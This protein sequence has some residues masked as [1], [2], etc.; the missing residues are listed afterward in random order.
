MLTFL[1]DVLKLAAFH[2]R[3]AR[4]SSLSFVVLLVLAFP[5][6]THLQMS[7][8][9]ERVAVAPRLSYVPYKPAS[10]LL[11]LPPPLQLTL[12][13]A[14]KPTSPRSFTTIESLLL[15]LT[16]ARPIFGH[17]HADF[18]H[19]LADITTPVHDHLL[20]AQNYLPIDLAVNSTLIKLSINLANISQKYI[21]RSPT[22]AST[23]SPCCPP[24]D[25]A[26]P[27]CL[28]EINALMPLNSLEANKLPLCPTEA[29]TLTPCCPLEVDTLPPL[30]PLEINSLPLHPL[31]INSLP[32]LLSSTGWWRTLSPT[33]LSYGLAALSPTQ[34]FYG[35]LIKELTAAH[36][37]QPFELS[38]ALSPQL[39]KELTAAHTPKPF[40]LSAALLL[41]TNSA[42]A[43]NVLSP[44]TLKNDM[45]TKQSA[46]A[47]NVLS[48]L[49][50]KT[51]MLA[52]QSALALNVLSPLTLKT[53]MLAEQSALALN[54]L[55]PLTLKTDM[56][57]EQSALA[58]NVLSPLT[59]KTDTLAEQSALAL[60]V[61]SPLTL[62]TDMLAE[63]SAL[64]LNVLSSL[65]LAAD[66]LSLSALQTIPLPP[67]EPPPCPIEAV[68]QAISPQSSSL[69]VHSSL[70][71]Y[72]QA[73]PSASA[74]SD[75]LAASS[76]L[77]YMHATPSVLAR[78]DALAASSPLHYMHATPS[79]SARSDALA[80]SSPPHYIHATPSASA[81]SDV[82]VPSSL[83]HFRKATPSALARS[84]ALAASSPPHYI[85]ATPSASARSDA[86]EASPLSART[87]SPARSAVTDTLSQ[88]H[89]LPSPARS[90]SCT[91]FAITGLLCHHQHA[92]A[93]AR[94][95]VAAPE[96][97]ALSPLL[98]TP[99]IQPQILSK[100]Q[101]HIRSKMQL[102][103]LSKDQSSRSW[104]HR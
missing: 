2:L 89:A 11:S 66:M 51:D 4:G 36:T 5:S 75:A 67:G 43:L 10:K 91:H 102:H 38:A 58:L 93:A 39:I 28:T 60:N 19:A 85:R 32:L 100:V 44:L 13:A 74:R 54:V 33:Q 82:L 15:P 64:A 6:S 90:R 88:L 83:L 92:L 20:D 35:L 52:E 3:P 7:T 55:S 76:P 41:A 101:L 14:P 17:A 50:L 12:A 31:E 96:P 1:A 70:L 46:L 63:Q 9:I 23:L 80:A 27:P 99:A 86:L 42:P 79:A 95:D 104:R 47:L 16:T 68:L 78:S 103:I 24:E 18:G 8:R 87:P 26:H 48:P 34:L 40:E 73:T 57:A 71:L 97:L 49:T 61:L 22:E 21:P 25:I 72:M 56:L 84:D 37:P 77:H 30:L 65:A 62:K 29:I 69:P 53:D 94:S 59:P 98:Q 81:R 45:L